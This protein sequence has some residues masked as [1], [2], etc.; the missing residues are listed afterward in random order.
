MNTAYAASESA[1]GGYTAFIPL[2]II[3]AGFGYFLMCMAKRKGRSPWSWFA[4]GFVPGWNFFA[5]IWLAS[6]PDAAITEQL[7]S[8]LEELQ[9]INPAL[10]DGRSTEQATWTCACG[11]RNSMET[12]N[13]PE[14]GLK[15]DFLLKQRPGREG[16]ESR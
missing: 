11:K 4:A 5:A 9:K 16:A 10:K 8:L 2:L 13:C 14:C 12:T 3:G 15:R 1:T 6:L 7:A